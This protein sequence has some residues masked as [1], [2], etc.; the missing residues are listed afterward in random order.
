MNVLYYDSE[1]HP[2]RLSMVRMDGVKKTF[3][4]PNNELRTE[5]SLFILRLCDWTDQTKN[6][7]VLAL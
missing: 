2:Q 3:T 5:Q 6:S 4:V 7:L 1:S